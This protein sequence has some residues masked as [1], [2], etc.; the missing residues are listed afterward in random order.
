[1]PEPSICSTRRSAGKSPL[2]SLTIA[3]W[4]SVSANASTAPESVSTQCT[5]SADDVS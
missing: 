2:S 1:M 5:C 3:V 4:A